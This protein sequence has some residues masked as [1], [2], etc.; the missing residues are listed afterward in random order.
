MI[1]ETKTPHGEGAVETPAPDGQLAPAVSPPTIQR[2]YTVPGRP[3]AEQASPTPP[4]PAAAPANSPDP[5][6]WIILIA[7]LTGAFL[8]LLDTT[9][10]N[11]A[12]RQMGGNLGATQDEIGWVATGYILSNVVVLPMTAWLSSVFGRRRYLT[13]SIL[14]FTLTSIMCG[15]SDSLAELVFWRILQGAGGA[16]LLSTA[17]ATLREVFPVEQQGMIQALYTV[18]VVIGPTLGPTFGGWITDNYSWQCIFL[19]K[20]P[21]GFIAAALVWRFLKESAH[22]Q[23]T[24]AA[25]WQGILLLTA[26]LGSLQY[27]LEEGERYDWLNDVTIARL[28]VVAAVTLTAFIAWELSTRNRHPVVNLRV[29]RNKELAAGSLLLLVGGFG[30]YGGTFILPIFAQG[31]LGFTATNTG[32]MFLPG[33][34]ATVA[35][36]LI[37][38]RL[39]NGAKP[40]MKPVPLIIGGM[41]A[42]SISQWMLS[43]M[44]VETGESEIVLALIL[45]GGG[46]GF[47]LSPITQASLG[48]L[49]GIEIS[50]GAG[51]TNLA[52]QLGGSFGIAI[53]NT[54]VVDQTAVHRADLVQYVFSGSPWLAARHS[55]LAAH[56][57]S[58]GYNASGAQLAASAV[59]DHAVQTQSTVMAYNDAFL[60]IGLS[61]ALSIPLALLFVRRRE[62]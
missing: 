17:Q 10:V 57:I 38:G 28:A 13:W 30:I 22:K 3:R 51:L 12:L 44:T 15:L 7:V 47:V 20:S 16:A 59:V 42:F 19:L 27:V 4:R 8:E 41:I 33:G 49:K 56:M 39:L 29:L 21:L 32:L 14:L 18:V 31:V 53:V 35:G 48:T 50:Q 11:V 34:L 37:A 6:R 60:L 55:A 40:L 36:T 58:F 25:D 43:Q 52:R 26:G 1:T 2:D 23:A 61:F 9:S 62:S 45:R 5:H 54:F 24:N 46:L